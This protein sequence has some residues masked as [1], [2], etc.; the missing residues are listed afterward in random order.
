MLPILGSLIYFAYGVRHSHPA[1]DSETDVLLDEKEWLY[2]YS[3]AIIGKILTQDL[4]V[5]NN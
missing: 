5:F 3:F 1:D 4:I 2:Q